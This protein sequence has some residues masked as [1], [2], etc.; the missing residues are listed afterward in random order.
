MRAAISAA[1]GTVVAALALA[2]APTVYA[3]DEAWGAI[4]V[5]PDGQAVGVATNQP[6]EYL[7]NTVANS[8]CQQNN[9]ACN[10]LI[11]FK[12]PDCGAVAKN[13][14]QYFGDSG[15]TQQQAEQNAMNQSPGSTVLRSACNNPA[16]GA[17]TTPTSTS[18][19]TTPS[20]TTTAPAGG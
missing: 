1:S 8:D 18:A 11:T 10:V 7:A 6:N 17:S 13:G 9:P 12:D 3:E 20:T 15:A 14:D 19:S 16:A 2:V 5:S 4:S